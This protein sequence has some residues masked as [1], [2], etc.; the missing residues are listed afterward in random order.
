MF[1][2]EPTTALQRSNMVAFKKVADERQRLV[3]MCFEEPMA[4]TFDQMQFGVGQ[5]AEVRPRGLVVAD[6]QERSRYRGG[7]R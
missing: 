6:L 7:H 3:E 4:S 5:V 2:S 1:R